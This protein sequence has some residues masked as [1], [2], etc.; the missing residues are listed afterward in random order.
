MQIKKYRKFYRYTYCCSMILVLL[1]SCD[2]AATTPLKRRVPDGF[3]S[4]QQHCVGR[5]AEYVLP[6]LLSGTF[7]LIEARFK[8]KYIDTNITER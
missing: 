3:L 7:P 5:C 1:L 2:T 6:G 4:Q 8:R